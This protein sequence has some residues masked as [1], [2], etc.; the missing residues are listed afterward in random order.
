MAGLA[1]STQR[2]YRSG[3]RRYLLFCSMTGESPYPA[4]EHRLTQFIA[5]LFEQGLGTSTMKG[6]L[7]A[8]RHA[9]IALGLGDPVMTQMPQ[10][11]YVLRGACHNTTGRQGRTRLPITPEI[12]DRLRGTWEQHP[13]RRDAVM[14][15]AASTLCF[16][17]FLGM[18][19][20]VAPSDSGFGPRYHLA[21]GDV[22]FNS[23]VDPEW[24]EV[25]IKRSKCD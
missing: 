11:Q 16:F 3:E 14:L 23:S 15:W 24:M 18:G 20:A 9:Q 2:T 13:S 19:E 21:Y 22:R 7:A 12:L 10:L 6:Y 5:H 25:W 8:V 1:A 4:T 17:A